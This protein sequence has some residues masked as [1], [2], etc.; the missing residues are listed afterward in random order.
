M[1]FVAVA[2]K[3]LVYVADLSNKRV[4]VF[5]RSGTCLHIIETHGDSPFDEAVTAA[6]E[7]ITRDSPV[8]VRLLALYS[9][10]FHSAV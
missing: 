2:D 5:T 7:V 10:D 4:Q 3:V 1:G 6:G 8:Q 9:I